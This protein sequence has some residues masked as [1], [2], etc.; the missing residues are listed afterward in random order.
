MSGFAACSGGLGRV[1]VGAAQSGNTPAQYVTFYAFT[2]DAQRPAPKPANPPRQLVTTNTCVDGQGNTSTTTASSATFTETDASYPAFPVAPVCPSGTHLAGSTVVET[3]PGLPTKTI[4]QFSVPTHVQQWQQNFPEC[5][6][7]S[8]RL[9][10]T[11][12]GPSGS[13]LGDCFAEQGRC[14]GWFTDPNKTEDYQCTYGPPAS[15]SNVDITE[16][17]T[18]SGYFDP[19]DQAKGTPYGDPATGAIPTTS[20]TT[21]TGTTTTTDSPDPS[22]AAASPDG[23]SCFPSG[24]ASVMNP[25]E[26]VL[27]PIKCALT[28]AFVPSTSTL[29]DLESQVTTGLN[30]TG[31]GEW[32]SALSGLFGKLGGSG[33]GCTGPTVTFP[34]T[35]TAMQ[36]FNACSDPMKTVA[37]V[38]YAFSTLAL[39]VFGA[40]AGLRIVGGAFGVSVPFGGQPK[41]EV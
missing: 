22:G 27:Q 7:G 36:P 39:V 38:S 32:G 12:I 37:S 23:V 21:S 14:T 29:A 25:V 41:A 34:M 26:W 16:C 8:C 11:K 40:V 6:D 1:W 17:N 35:N 20:V 13:D 15:P 10:L 18:Y 4:W 5:G 33:S 19:A 24:W 3:S 2:G 31:V 30:G 9:G 28:W